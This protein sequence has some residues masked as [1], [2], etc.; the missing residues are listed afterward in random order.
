[1]SCK[2]DVALPRNALSNIRQ[3]QVDSGTASTSV[4]GCLNGLQFG[5]SVAASG[6]SNAVRRYGAVKH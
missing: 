3:M 4:V 2:A 5:P 1:M 6:R